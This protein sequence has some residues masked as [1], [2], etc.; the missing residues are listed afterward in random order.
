MDK[1][2]CA[3]LEIVRVRVPVRDEDATRER[4]CRI[5]CVV[6]ALVSCTV[7]AAHTHVRCG[8]SSLC[9]ERR[10]ARF[11]CL[12]LTSGS[13]ALLKSVP[14]PPGNRKVYVT[15]PVPRRS[16]PGRASSVRHGILTVSEPTLRRLCT[17]WRVET[18]ASRRPRTRS[19]TSMHR[20]PHP[21]PSCVAK[22]WQEARGH[23]CSVSLSLSLSLSLFVVLD[24]RGQGVHFVQP[25]AS[26][27]DLCVS[28]PDPSPITAIS[29]RCPSSRPSRTSRSTGR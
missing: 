4:V 9:F 2:G 15:E 27:C 24:V 11:K 16:P 29:P 7:Y 19:R 10:D 18:E 26:T 6:L 8:R 25:G 23:Q 14:P 20:Y 28:T 1:C 22:P 17:C 21:D 5:R 3:P 13:H 12:L